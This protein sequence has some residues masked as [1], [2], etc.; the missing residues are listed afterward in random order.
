MGVV[1]AGGKVAVQQAGRVPPLATMPAY[2]DWDPITVGAARGIVRATAPTW[3][4]AT[5]SVRPA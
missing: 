4:S 5:A 3:S 1:R 2:T